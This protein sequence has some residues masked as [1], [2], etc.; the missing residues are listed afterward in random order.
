MGDGGEVVHVCC[1]VAIVARPHPWAFHT[2]VFPEN[3]DDERAT[4]L[5]ASVRNI[6]GSDYT[7]HQTRHSAQIVANIQNNILHYDHINPIRNVKKNIVS[8]LLRFL[9]IK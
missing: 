4:G 5:T 2:P 8:Y 6:I 3:L 9:I 1:H 7:Q